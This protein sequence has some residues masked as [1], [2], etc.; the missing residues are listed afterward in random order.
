MGFYELLA[1]FCFIYALVIAIGG[2]AIHQRPKSRLK[3]KKFS[4][5]GLT[6]AHEYVIM[7]KTR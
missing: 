7:N 5:K 3:T 4:R 2:I 1:T 6:K